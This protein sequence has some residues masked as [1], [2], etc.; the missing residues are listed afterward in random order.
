MSNSLFQTVDDADEAA[1]TW[2]AMID[3]LMLYVI[4]WP[5]AVF[6]NRKYSDHDFYKLSHRSKHRFVWLCSFAAALQINILMNL[7]L[8]P[9]FHQQIAWTTNFV[10]IVSYA[11]F[12]LIRV[13][14]WLNIRADDI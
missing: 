11:I 5:W 3:L 2:L 1:F 12:T 4:R 7:C 13:A 10:L 8:L 14:V 6:W 9:I